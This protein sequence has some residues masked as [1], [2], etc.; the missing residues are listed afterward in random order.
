MR[1]PGLLAVIALAAC[2]DDG[3]TPPDANLGTPSI[4][5]TPVSSF[6][7]TACATST[8]LALSIQI[9]QEVDCLNPG[10]LVVFDESATITFSG[11]AV[12][13]YLSTQ[14]R[15]SLLAA[16]DAGGGKVMAV[17]SVFRTVVQQYLLRRWFELGRCGITAAAQPGSSNHESG[18]AID[19]SNYSEWIAGLEAQGLAHDV[20]GD[21]VHFDHL[22]SPDIR[23]A[24]VL[25]FQRLWNKNAPDD[26]IGED[27]SYGAQTEER[28]KRA[29]AEGFGIGASCA[30]RLAPPMRLPSDVTTQDPPCA[31]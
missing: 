25:A 1:C 6:E 24:D 10:Q 23:G 30:S 29:P 17:T 4:D 12:L 9:A 14:A 19:L 20:P 26:P 8:V 15:T 21:P 28:V 22:S 2:G 18:R 13:P 27:G 11:S 5:G 16:A 7:S 31:H 3:A